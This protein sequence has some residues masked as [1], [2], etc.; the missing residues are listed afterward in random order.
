ML[1]FFIANGHDHRFTGKIY[2]LLNN[3]DNHENFLPQKF[4]HIHYLSGSFFDPLTHL[5][6][7]AIVGI[8]HIIT[9]NQSTKRH[10]CFSY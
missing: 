1:V 9:H 4:S 10:T 7:E 6:T 3:C 8:I 5:E 2:G